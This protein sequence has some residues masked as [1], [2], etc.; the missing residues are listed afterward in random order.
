MLPVLRYS[1]QHVELERMDN[2]TLSR[3]RAQGTEGTGLVSG[4]DSTGMLY[5]RGAPVRSPLLKPWEE[6]KLVYY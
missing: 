1:L 3:T 6:E 4:C 2:R 5:S